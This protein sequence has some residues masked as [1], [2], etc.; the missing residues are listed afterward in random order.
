MAPQ[1]VRIV[2]PVVVAIAML[3]PGNARI[4]VAR[5]GV[6]GV[7]LWRVEAGGEES[8]SVFERRAR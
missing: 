5:E 6:S 4:W 3:P 7:I 1:G 8:K 2:R